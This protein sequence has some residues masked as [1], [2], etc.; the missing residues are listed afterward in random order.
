MTEP[1]SVGRRCGLYLHHSSGDGGG[2]LE[3]DNLFLKTPVEKSSHSCE[4]TPQG[5]SSWP[6]LGVSVTVGGSVCS[7]AWEAFPS[8]LKEPEVETRPRGLKHRM[9]FIPSRGSQ[10]ELRHRPPALSLWHF[11]KHLAQS[12]RF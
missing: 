5:Q 4:N 7:R 12:L 11:S 8:S 10:S 9:I 2:Q 1:L 3:D 6:V